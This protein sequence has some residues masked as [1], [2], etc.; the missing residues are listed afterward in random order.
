MTNSVHP[1]VAAVLGRQAWSLQNP[2]ERIG[3]VQ[4]VF[5]SA[6]GESDDVTAAALVQCLTGALYAQYV[7][8]E[9]PLPIEVFRYLK[10]VY[11]NVML[12]INPHKSRM[13]ATRQALFQSILG[14]WRGEDHGEASVA[15]FEW[16]CAVANPMRGCDTEVSEWTSA[17]KSCR[18]ALVGEERQSMVDWFE[19]RCKDSLLPLHSIDWWI[20]KYESVPDFP[21]NVIVIL[22][23]EQARKGGLDLVRKRISARRTCAALTGSDASVG[24]WEFCQDVAAKTAVFDKEVRQKVVAPIIAGREALFAGSGESG[25]VALRYSEYPIGGHVLVT[26]MLPKNPP[27]GMS[28]EMRVRI[29]LHAFNFFMEDR[30]RKVYARLTHFGGIEVERWAYAEPSFESGG[31]NDD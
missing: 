2:R 3:S 7:D 11:E 26:V 29:N 20:E 16:C 19:S 6:C 23:M 1:K 14:L 9:S 21:K 31:R 25:N 8:R 10:I 18:W 13:A 4:S 15:A 22:A 24:A 28:E 12:G 17:M 27:L 5:E 30:S